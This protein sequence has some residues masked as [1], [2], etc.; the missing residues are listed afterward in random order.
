M[1]VN[2]ALGTIPSGPD[3]GGGT[4]NGSG[5]N[6]KGYA[7]VPIGKTPTL[8]FSDG[9]GGGPYPGGGSPYPGGGGGL[10]PPGGNPLRPS[11]R[12][13]FLAPSMGQVEIPIPA[14]PRM[15]A[16]IPAAA[17]ILSGPPGLTHQSRRQRPV[18]RGRKSV[19]RQRVRMPTNR[20]ARV[21]R[22]RLPG[23]QV[24]FPIQAAVRE[25][26]RKIRTPGADLLLQMELLFQ[27]AVRESVRKFSPRAVPRPQVELPIPAAV[28]RTARKPG[29]PAPAAAPRPKVYSYPGVRQSPCADPGR[30]SLAPALPIRSVNRKPASPFPADR[31]DRRRRWPTGIRRAASAAAAARGTAA[32]R[33]LCLWP[34]HHARRLQPRE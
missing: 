27:A 22:R 24:E 34:P 29:R 3:N 33:W 21:R 11:A 4:S 16:L 7:F 28:Q 26:V 5:S 14:A 32:A 25:M 9:S 30:S 13:C 31:P 6:G 10:D 17:A 12:V 19:S 18:H 23:S 2:L 20:I 15:A 1:M 8:A